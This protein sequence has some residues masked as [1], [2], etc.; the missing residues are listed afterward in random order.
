MRPEQTTVALIAWAL[1]LGFIA[2]LG[3]AGYWLVPLWMWLRPARMTARP[4]ALAPVRTR[5]LLPLP[6]EAALAQHEAPLTR[7]GFAPSVPVRDARD[8]S[9]VRGGASGVVQLWRHADDGTIASLMVSPTG[10]TSALAVLWLTTR[11]ADGTT[12][13]TMNLPMPSSFP[14]PADFRRAR[15]PDERAPQRLLTLHR[16]RVREL[17]KT[18]PEPMDDPVAFQYAREQ[19]ALDWFVSS[20]YMRRS[21]DRLRH[22]FRGAFG[23]VYRQLLIWR[24]LDGRRNEAERRR[25]LVA[26]GL[27]TST[28]PS[29]SLGSRLLFE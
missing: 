28:G 4:P 17:G 14:A 19:K 6:L 25:L 10:A 24:W 7:L 5:S 1:F 20:G 26:A 9:K 22:T 3:T 18:D 2:I 16:A 15:F 29:K 12:V 11:L 8:V 13:E 21:G 27:P 23:S